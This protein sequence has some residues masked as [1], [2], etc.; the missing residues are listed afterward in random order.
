[1]ANHA[2]L[3]VL[4]GPRD[5]GLARK[6]IADSGYKGEPIVLISPT[7]TPPFAALAQ[8]ARGLFLELGLNVDFKEMDFGS[9]ITRRVSQAPPANGGWNCFNQLWAT[10]NATNPGNSLALRA[11][12]KG[13]SFGWPTDDPLEAMRQEWF[14]APDLASQRAICERIQRRALEVVPGIPLGQVTMPTAFRSNVS[15]IVKTPYPAFW[16][17]RKG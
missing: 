5:L 7:D 12:G 9:V 3:E 11:N 4:T 17:V 1:M 2:G 13:A 16:N 15:G 10:A 14:D 8:V 6:L